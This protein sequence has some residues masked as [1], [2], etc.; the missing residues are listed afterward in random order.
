MYWFREGEPYTWLLI[1]PF[2]LLIQLGGWLI[3]SHAYKLRP[4]ERLITGGAIGGAT[5]GWVMIYTL[6]REDVR[7]IENV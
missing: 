4:R 5:G 7:Q 3:S 6:R 2:A 1:I